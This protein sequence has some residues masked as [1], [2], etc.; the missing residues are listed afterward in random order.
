[1]LKQ[2]F[3]LSVT[4]FLFSNAGF[5]QKI[6]NEKVKVLIEK[7]KVDERGPYKDIRWF[8]EDG[9][10]IMPKEKCPSGGVQRARYKD[11]V[12]SLG[13]TNHIFLGQILANTP[14]E[15]FWDEENYNSRLKQY[16]LEKYLRAIDDGW[17]LQKG[18]YYRGAFQVEY[19]EAWGIEFL[20]WLLKDDAIP[21]QQFFLMR[22]AVKDIPHRGDDNKT[23]NVRAVSKNIADNYPAFNKLRIKIHGQPEAADIPKVRKFKEENK[24]KLS[25]DLLKKFDVLLADMEDVYQPADLTSLNVFLKEIPGSALIG[26]SLKEYVQ[27]F[28]N[29]KNSI[30]RT[31]ATAEKLAEIRTA[32][33]TLESSKARLAL[34]D[35]SNALEE[36]FFSELSNWNPTTVEDITDKI[37]YA[38]MAA[39]GT[40]FIEIWEWEE[41]LPSLAVSNKEEMTLSELNLYLTRARDLVEWGTGMV[42]GV[43][44][45]VVNLYDGFEPMAH[46]FFDDRIR[47]SVLLG[48]GNSVSDLG[49]FLTRKSKLTNKI[50]DIPNQ[51]AVRGLNPGF[52]FGE[53]VVMNDLKEDMEVSKDKIY[54]FYNPPSDLKPVAGI[55]TVTEGNMV[56]HVQLLARNLGIPNAVVSANNLDWLKRYSGK[57]VFY[58]VSNQGTVIMKANDKMTPTEKAL[59]AEKK[60]S[61]ERITVP[62]EK[63]DLS[64]TSVINMRAVNAASSGKICGPKAA[65]LG[66]LKMMFPDNVV[67]GL[68]LPFGIFRQHLDQKM[69][70][71]EGTYWTFLNAT[72]QQANEMKENGKT[73]EEIESYSLEQ[74]AILREAIKKIELLPDF[75][76][77]LEENFKK[78]FDQKMGGIPVFL[79]SDTNMEDLKDFTGAGLNLTVFNAVD[80]AKILQGIKDVWASP[81]TERSFKWRQ[82]YL[83][84][85]ENVFPSILII[86]SVDVEYSGVLIT[87][88]I[89]TNDGRDL[90]IAFSRGAGGAVDGQAA[91]SYLLYHDGENRLLSPAREPQYRQLP[92]TGGSKMNYTTFENPI[93]ND[94]NLYDLR[95]LA[96]NVHQEIP[97]ATTP[98][99]TGPFDVELGFKEDK[100]WLFQIRPFVE[101]KNAASSAYLESI[102]PKI[103][104]GKKV[105]L[106]EKIMIE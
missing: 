1:M 70:E 26:K 15:D 11:E 73:E 28:Q 16:Q 92:E 37:C 55:L 76:S 90:T 75:V 45:D 91:E 79:R 17:V 23:L 58:A 40:G 10:V 95:W 50:M 25:T 46:G 100:I 74:L 102:S 59:F 99:N 33:L 36:I 71:T 86:P 2:I 60:R 39:M 18:Q 42:H 52:A 41:L 47:G 12:E 7:Y 56:S 48:L 104:K 8:C 87:K 57:K 9:S 97:K 65:N 35:I 93:L 78:A 82:R 84:N 30:A 19:E 27:L 21:E 22:Q 44:K 63:V 72:F 94:Q 77:D 13:K 5:S 85:P 66:Q 14:N 62:V 49:K 64:Q 32:L 98:D 3:F 89:P 20:N 88:G 31:M 69:P 83:L 54:A 101:N 103:D 34:M 4:L 6:D 80:R 38:G 29:E 67:E 51:S 81:Y 53:L 105:L 106:T 24:A 68:V 96:Y 61:E 43:Y